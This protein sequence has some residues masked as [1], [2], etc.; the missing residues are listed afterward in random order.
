M[1]YFQLANSREGPNEE[2]GFHFSEDHLTMASKI[3]LL[4]KWL[5][6]PQLIRAQQ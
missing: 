5:S 6:I 1:L 3:P 2:K 4:P